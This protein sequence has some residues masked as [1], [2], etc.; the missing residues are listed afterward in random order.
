MAPTANR[1]RDNILSAMQRRINKIKLIL[2]EGDF[3]FFDDMWW[4]QVKR[5]NN[6]KFLI[7]GDHHNIKY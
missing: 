2:P 5:K 6:N 4:E 3:L 7:R 1:L